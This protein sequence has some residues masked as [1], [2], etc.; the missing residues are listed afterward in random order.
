MDSLLLT[1]ITLSLGVFF[2]HIL[3]KLFHTPLQSDLL[4]IFLLGIIVSTVYF[5]I[6]SFWFPVNYLSLAPLL[7][8]SL[9]IQLLLP[10]KVREIRAAIRHSGKFIFSAPHLFISL[11]VLITLFFYWMI[12]PGNVDSA[13]Y[14]YESIHWYEKY[15]AVPGLANL[16]GRLA[17]NP[18]SFI[19]QAAY[20][21]TDLTGQSLYPLNGVL[22]ALFF[23]WLL[24]RLFRSGNSLTA[25]IYGALIF[26]LYKPLLVNISSPSSDTLVAVC[27]CYSLISLFHI[28]QT[29]EIALKKAGIPCLIIIYSLIAKLSSFPVLLVLP[30][31]FFLLPKSERKLSLLL[32]ITVLSGLLYLPWLGRNY[33]LSGYLTYPFPFLDIFHPDWKAPLTILR[34]E[35][36]SINIWSKTG[37]T[38]FLLS[39]PPSLAQW[40]GPWLSS[41]YAHRTPFDPVFFFVAMI[42]PLYWLIVYFKKKRID[43]PLFL[44]W[45]IIYIGIWIWFLSC[46]VLRF[47]AVLLSLSI[48]FP[49]WALAAPQ[50]EAAATPQ[51]YP[52]TTPRPYA[53]ATPK[54]HAP[55]RLPTRLLQLFFACSVIYYIFSGYTRPTTYTFTLGDCWL[56]PLKDITYDNRQR[57]DFPYR[58][59]QSG[60]KMYI[61][62][63]NHQCINADLPCMVNLYGEVEMRGQ[64]ID[65]G[66]K[67][68]K[69][70][71]L[72]HAPYIQ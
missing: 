46:P 45:L 29:K 70:A 22:L 66:F 12:P 40:F 16:N 39:A 24:I 72:M 49:A 67:T 62:D 4:G 18:A 36:Y 26:M 37:D 41:F 13:G 8:L 64:H 57:K 23:G 10:Q 69:D 50:A 2:L 52:A 42:S 1:F 55:P 21:F 43:L 25:L 54:P 3:E 53:P 11:C 68:V 15:K 48:A 31:I 51:P 65:Q 20:S 17:F 5:N 58:I 28:L 6:L 35:M 9:L 34:L 47:G 32:K 60:T 63:S 38:Q 7:G 59:L 27:L 14:H 71:V 33:I 61:S 19:I 30:Y 44:L 56:Y